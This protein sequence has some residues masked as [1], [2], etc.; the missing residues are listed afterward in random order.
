MYL[1][2]TIFVFTGS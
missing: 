2:T 1:L